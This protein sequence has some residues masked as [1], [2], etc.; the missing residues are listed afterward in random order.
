M[1]FLGP[2]FKK[3]KKRMKLNYETMTNIKAK[4]FLEKFK[5]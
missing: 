5:K 3:I 1:K 4:N 2:E